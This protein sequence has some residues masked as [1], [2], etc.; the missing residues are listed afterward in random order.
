MRL[1]PALLL[2]T[3]L[4]AQP[5]LA[6][7]ITHEGAQQLEQKFTSYLPEKLAKSGLVRVRPGTTDYE[8]TFDPTV[9]L[10]DVDPKTFSISGLTPFLSLIRP[11]EDGSWNF[12]QS[13]D[14]DVKGQFTAGTEKTDFSYQINAFR[15]D[16]IYDPDILYF[17]S[18]EMTAGGISMRS[19]SPVQSVEARFGTMKSVFDSKRATADTIDIRSNTAMGAFAE[20][21]IDPAKAR[22]DLSADSV[23]ADIA[24]NGMAYRPLHDIVFFILDRVKTERLTPEEQARVKTLLRANLPMFDALLESIDVTNLKVATPNGTFG[25]ET[26]RYTINSNGLRD[27]AKAGFGIVVDKPSVPAGVVP[28]AFVAALPET[29]SFRASFENLNLSSGIGYFLDHADFNAEK[30]LTDEQ[31]TAAGGIFLPGGAL[32]MRYEDVSARS[33]VY[34]ISLSGTTTLYPEQKDRQNTD[35]TIYARDFDKTISYLQQNAQAVPQFGQA[36]FVLLMVKGFAK[37]E[38]DGRQMWNVVVDEGGKMK[39]NGQ[40]LAIPH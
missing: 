36:A 34:D 30:P 4:V 17:K 25:A 10:K 14:F 5:L 6:A 31:S 9:L 22:I 27:G 13:A 21:V 18:G 16:G 29:I 15:M 24:V 2:S 7:D 38:A 8:V 23:T 1:I 20:S 40:E 39:I 33:S 28:E 32:T 35:V 12:S 3:A 11:L 26:L 19:N 37:T